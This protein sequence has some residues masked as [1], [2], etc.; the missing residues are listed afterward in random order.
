LG[1]DVSDL[2]AKMKASTAFKKGDPGMKA[3]VSDCR[4]EMNNFVS[5]YRRNNKVAGAASFSTLYTAISTL[6]GHF[7]SYGDEYPVPEKRKKVPAP[8]RPT[9][10]PPGRRGGALPGP[11]VR[12]RG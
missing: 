9:P 6:S 3:V 5:Y 10:P 7:Q 2:L 12:A 11:R 1:A 8:P 4:V